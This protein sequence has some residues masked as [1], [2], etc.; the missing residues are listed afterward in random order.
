M[1]PFRTFER[2][3][4]STARLPRL[5]GIHLATLPFHSGTL[6]PIRRSETPAVSLPPSPFG[7]PDQGVAGQRTDK[8]GHCHAAAPVTGIGK[9]AL[10]SAYLRLRFFRGPPRGV[11]RPAG[12]STCRPPRARLLAGVP[13]TAPPA[14]PE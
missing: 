1:L 11:V 9:S 12:S 6:D 7:R 13:P 10:P 3:V 4:V 14:G 5:P 8:P 2:V